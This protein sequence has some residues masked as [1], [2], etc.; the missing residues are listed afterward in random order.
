MDFAAAAAAATAFQ[1]QFRQANG[2]AGGFA[3]SLLEGC[4]FLSA[5]GF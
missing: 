3:E 1:Y 4:C 2:M 5:R